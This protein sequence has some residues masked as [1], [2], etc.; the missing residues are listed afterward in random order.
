MALNTEDKL[1]NNK[2]SSY[3]HE[4]EEEEEEEEGEYGEEDE[5][6]ESDVDHS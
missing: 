4:D 2:D 6:A 1:V 5:E 3:D